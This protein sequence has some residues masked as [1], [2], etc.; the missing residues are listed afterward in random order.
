M[1]VIARRVAPKQ[2]S[3]PRC[4][5]G[6]PPTASTCQSEVVGDL[7]E[8]AVRGQAYPHWNGYVEADFSASRVGRRGTGCSAPAAEAQGSIEVFCEAGTDGGGAG[9]VRR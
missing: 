4:W 2:S 1:V 3:R 8:E 7:T 5:G 9:G 6:R